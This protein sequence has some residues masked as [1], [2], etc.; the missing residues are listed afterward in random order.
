MILNRGHFSKPQT[1]TGAATRNRRVFSGGANPPNKGSKSIAGDK[2]SKF[3]GERSHHQ[4]FEA[5]TITS[6]VSFPGF[7]SDFDKQAKNSSYSRGAIN[8]GPGV[9]YTKTSGYPGLDQQ[10][11]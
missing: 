8:R 11:L 9:T 3:G 10:Q 5:N 2:K 7:A 4:L 1:A 6:N